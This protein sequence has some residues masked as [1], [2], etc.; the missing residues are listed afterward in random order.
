MSVIYG[1]PVRLLEIFQNLLDNAV[2]FMGDEPE[3]RIEIDAATRDADVVCS[4]RDNGIGIAPKYHEKVFGLFEQLH[5]HVDG[6]GIGLTLL[7][8]IYT[9]GGCDLRPLSG[10]Q[11]RFGNDSERYARLFDAAISPDGL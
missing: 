5:Q 11:L 9:H 10:G 3:P 1:D 4:V 8:V 6:T 7:P 2:K